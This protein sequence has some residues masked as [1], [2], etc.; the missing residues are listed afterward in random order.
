MVNPS[1]RRF[2]VNDTY[3]GADKTRTL[4]VY[5]ID[6]E[7]RW[8]IG[9]FRMLDARPDLDAFD[10][11]AVVQGIDRR[12]LRKFPRDLMFFTRSGLHCDLHPRWNAQGTQIAFD[13][14]HD[15]T[16]QVYIGDCQGF[17]HE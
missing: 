4:M 8:D 14:I 11:T 15:G 6:T 9:R 16:R 5:R 12:V 2:L 3:P 7:E 10:T 1:D 13:S 17:V